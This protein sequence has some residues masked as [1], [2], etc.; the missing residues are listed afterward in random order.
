MT[1]KRELPLNGIKVVITR[2][3]DQ[4]A[5]AKEIFTNVGAIVLDLPA[6]LIGPPDDWTSLDN[7]LL[8]IHCFNWI[9]FSSS[10]GVNAVNQRLQIMGKS[11]LSLPA[12][13]KIAAVGRKTALNLEHLGAQ[14]DFVPPE[15]VAES[16]IKHFPFN[17]NQN[18]ILLPRVQSG[19]R[20]FLA[21]AFVTVLL[22]APAGPSIA[23]IGFRF[24]RKMWSI[25]RVFPQWTAAASKQNLVL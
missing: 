25:R 4:Q 5:A 10:N 20:S 3:Q 1:S 9:V 21:K 13:L 6:L 23:T 19:G 8:N 15:F 12:T 17:S 11:F 22:P 14:I 24:I 7:A 18:A 2:S 16:L